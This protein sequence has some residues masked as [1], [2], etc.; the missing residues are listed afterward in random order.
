M[1]ICGAELIWGQEQMASGIDKP[2][3]LTIA[4]LDML[5]Q[6]AILYS[7]LG[8][9]DFKIFLFLIFLKTYKEKM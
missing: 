5:L 9:L 8:N 2:T 4:F 3:K 1:N 7:F 6:I